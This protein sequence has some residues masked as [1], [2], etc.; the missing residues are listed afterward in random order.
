MSTEIAEKPDH[1]LAQAEPTPMQLIQQALAAGVGPDV[2]ERLVALKNSMEDRAAKQAFIEAV[3]RFKENMPEI[4]KTKLVNAGKMTYRHAEL[5]KISDILE[6]ELTKYQLSVRW[7]SKPRDNGTL[8]MNCVVTHA[9]GYSER[10]SLAGPPDQSGGKNSLQAIGSASSYLQR[11]TLLLALGIVARGVDDD[12]RAGQGDPNEMV[13]PEEA[14]E[15]VKGM[16]ETRADFGR[17]L[18]FFGVQDAKDIPRCQL[19]VA[20]RL[21]SEKRKAK[22]Q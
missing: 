19:E 16:N 2:L 14:A 22:K 1:R 15:I 6:P 17:F 18:G 20:R 12:G 9:L 4:V 10:S 8:E 5:D 7:E 21:I 13:T 11:Y 3:A